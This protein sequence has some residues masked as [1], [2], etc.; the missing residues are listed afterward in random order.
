M[1][2]FAPKLDAGG[3]IPWVLLVLAAAVGKVW[4]SREKAANDLKLAA[5][6]ALGDLKEAH[7]RELGDLKA[8]HAREL[9]RVETQLEREQAT[10][11]KLGKK[12]DDEA[13]LRQKIEWK[14]AQLVV[15]LRFSGRGM[16]DELEPEMPT[17]VRN[18]ADL[19]P[20][21]STPPGTRSPGRY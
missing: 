6:A 12:H 17:G 8:L 4:H 1:A 15:G 11:E 10:T 14:Y 13:A 7:A 3:V 18:L 20:R 9:A 16:P 21:S 19:M 5:Q 2:D